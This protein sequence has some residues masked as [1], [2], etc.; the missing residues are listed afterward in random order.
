M[1]IAIKILQFILSFSLLVII[2]EFGHFITAKM[3]GMR[4]EKFYMFFN[5][6][7]SLWKKEYKGT[8]YGIGWVPFGGYVK[9]AGMIDESMDKEQMA[10]PPQPWEFRSKKP[11]QRLI[12]MAAGVV[13]NALLAMC[14]YIGLT[15]KYG[16]SYIAD[17]DASNGYVFNDMAQGMGF[18][19]GDRI[20]S[21][22]DD[23][24][25]SYDELAGRI[26][27]DGVRKVTVSRDGSKR[28]ISIADSMVKKMLEAQGAQQPFIS[29]RTRFVVAAIPGD[30]HNAAAGLLPGDTLIALNR[31]PVDFYDRWVPRLER[32][33]G[34]DAEIVVARSVEGRATT[35]TLTVSVDAEGHIGVFRQ[36][37]SQLLPIT[38]HKYTFLQSIPAGIRRTGD[39]VA[40]Y[41]KQLKLIF[42]PET[43]AYKQVGGVIAIGNFFP[44]QWSWYSF[45]S[46]TAFLSLMLA[47]LNI[48]PIPGLDGGHMVFCI[49]EMITG[50]KPN[51][52]FME[53][54]TTIGLIFL[55]G[56]ILLAN[57]ND[58]LKLFMK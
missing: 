22:G 55:F 57:G 10:Q 43:E 2:H 41:W 7:F 56:V 35:D 4:V 18:R 11:W 13:L 3:F 32:L 27:F 37:A 26:L 50:R 51:E 45:W 54:A 24:I 34:L 36:D 53:W 23:P 28:V 29:P 46:I 30:S 44:G 52:K 8:T 48:L 47:V 42:N 39:V 15:H 9:I 1:E 6:W 5:P 38:T 33:S 58:I 31:A 25:E 14:I 12:V 19:N 40:N 17:K 20:L 16:E 49:Y 21:V